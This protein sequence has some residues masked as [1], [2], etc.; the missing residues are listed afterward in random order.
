MPGYARQ[1]EPD[2]RWKTIH[3][4]RALQRAMNPEPQDL[5]P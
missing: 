3:Y 5:K 4:V 2:D 1:V